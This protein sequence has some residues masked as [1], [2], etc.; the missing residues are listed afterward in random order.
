MLVNVDIDVK[1]LLVGRS[2]GGGG[3]I[4]D[5]IGLAIGVDNDTSCVEGGEAP[6]E[7]RE[8]GEE[9]SGG[10]DRDVGEFGVVANTW[11]RPRT[12]VT[13][14]I[15]FFSPMAARRGRGGR[16]R[17]NME[18]LEKDRDAEIQALRRRVEELT[19]RLEHQEA[20]SERG[21]SHGYASDDSE[22]GFLDWLSAVE[23][24][25]EYK[26]ILDGQKVKLVA[27]RLRG[28]AYAWL[29]R[30]C[31]GV[32][33][34]NLLMFK[35]FILQRNQPVRAFQRKVETKMGLIRLRKINS[36]FKC[37]QLS[38]YM[39]EC[40]KR[41]SDARAGVVEK[42]DEEPPF[43][44]DNPRYDD[45]EHDREEIEPEEGECLVIQKVLA[46]PKQDENR[47]WLRHNIFR[48]R[49][50]SHGKV[51]SLVIDGGSFENFISQEMVGK[52]KLTT[53]PHPHPYSVS[54]IKK[55]NEIVYGR[56]PT[57][58]LDLTEVPT[59]SKTVEDFASTTERIQE[60]VKKKLLE[61]YQPYKR[62]ADVH[63]QIQPKSCK[64][65]GIGK[66]IQLSFQPYIT[67]SQM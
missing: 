29:N 63:R 9:G 58:Y 3:A 39:N 36:C 41:K 48:T 42:E 56:N 2:G 21:S 16:G 17:G 54:W 6:V 31:Y 14:L 59:S 23:K 53:M 43:E 40:L 24:F 18:N 62:A 4:V 61:S 65:G 20:R 49:C 55:D 28:Y 12:R 8:G 64:A 5:A 32:E 15:S 34:R 45:D 7:G 60:E 33:Q 25:F 35:A 46:A 44:E 27:T 30:N 26:D 66:L 37:G 57:H 22:H 38:H 51:C 1:Q 47:P 50:K 67:H 52:L 13:L 11:F 10:V 19:L